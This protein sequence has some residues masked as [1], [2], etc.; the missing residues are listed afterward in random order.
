MLENKIYI[1][2]RY[3]IFV[4]SFYEKTLRTTLFVRYKLYV[5]TVLFSYYDQTFSFNFALV[6]P[7]SA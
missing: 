1:L 3:A 5:R 4:F 7:A 6:F 2:M